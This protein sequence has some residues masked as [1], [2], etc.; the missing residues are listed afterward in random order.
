MSLNLDD[1]RAKR[2]VPDPYSMAEAYQKVIAGLHQIEHI[3]KLGVKT[4]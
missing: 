2:T 3:A 1:H 4:F